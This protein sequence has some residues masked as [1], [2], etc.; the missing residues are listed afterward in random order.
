MIARMTDDELLAHVYGSTDPVVR[1]L[2]ERWER[3]Q[4]KVETLQSMAGAASFEE[5]AK[6]LS[7]S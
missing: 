4:E 7:K 5:L 1:E 6:V 3:L 2:A